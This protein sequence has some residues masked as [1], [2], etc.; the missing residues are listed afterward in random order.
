LRIIRPGPTVVTQSPS[1][2]SEI[3]K[4][5]LSEILPFWFNLA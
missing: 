5:R 2:L 4:G 1:L 3:E